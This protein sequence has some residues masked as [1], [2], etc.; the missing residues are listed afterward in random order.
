M[1]NKEQ[2]S[3]FLPLYLPTDDG[4]VSDVVIG[5][6]EFRDGFLVINLRDTLP[7]MAVSRM[8]KRGEIL[9]LTFVKPEPKEGNDE[10]T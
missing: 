5:Q 6:G 10:T 7:G 8:L 2:E 3:V 9:G 1:E 4:G